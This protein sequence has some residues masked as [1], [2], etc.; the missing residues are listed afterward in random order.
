MVS[1]EHAGNVLVTNEKSVFGIFHNFI[2]P[3]CR[4]G[5]TDRQTDTQTD[6]Q[7]HRQTHRQTLIFIY[8]D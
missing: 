7:T 2:Q 5:H 4:N 3:N 1:M 8:I 6:T